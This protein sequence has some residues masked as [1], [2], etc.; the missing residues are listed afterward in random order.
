MW[1]NGIALSYKMKEIMPFA[2]TWLQLEILILRGVSLKEKDTYH[3]ISLIC[4]ILKMAQRSYLQNR[5]RLTN[6]EKTLVVAK[7]EE[8]R[9]GMDWELGI[10]RY[11]L[12][13]LEWLS[14]TG[15]G[16]CIQSLGKDQMEE[17][18]SERV[19]VYV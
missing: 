7:G 18:K 14:N 13:H 16:N 12:L 4:G 17:S 3:M 8:G 5:N 6:M 11:K 9:S 1:Y 2:A 10:S 15:T 19:C